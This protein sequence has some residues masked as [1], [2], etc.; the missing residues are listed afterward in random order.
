[1]R[2]LS[3]QSTL[4]TVQ[5]DSEVAASG[6]LLLQ[7]KET[8]AGLLVEESLVTVQDNGIAH[9]SLVNLTGF[10]Q[11]IDSGTTVGT[12]VE[13][14]EET[15]LPGEADDVKSATINQLVTSDELMERRQRL[16][17]MLTV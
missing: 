17:S 12:L 15:Q 8:M 2:V 7:P 3:N 16:A 5:V 1:M 6:Y 14:D 13:V 11:T 10:T 9:V 4:V